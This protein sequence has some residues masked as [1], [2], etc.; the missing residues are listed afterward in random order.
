MLVLQS[1]MD[2]QEYEKAQEYFQ[3]MSEGKVSAGEHYLTGN[4]I[5]DII[6]NAKAEKMKEAGI[7]VRCS[8]GLEGLKFMEPSDCCILFPI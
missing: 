1:L 2:K 3:K 7:Q 5:V 4:E 6:L 8:G